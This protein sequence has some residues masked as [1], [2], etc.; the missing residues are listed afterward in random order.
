VKTELERIDLS[1]PHDSL[2]ELIDERCAARNLGDF[3]LV[4][5]FVHQRQL[6]L[7]FQAE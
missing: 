4:G 5:T 3:K 6:V 1:Q 2:A 7:I